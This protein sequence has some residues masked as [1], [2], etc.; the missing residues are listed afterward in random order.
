MSLQSRLFLQHCVS[1]FGLPISVQEKRLLFWKL[2]N[3][4]R[5]LNNTRIA[6]FNPLF[7]ETRETEC[8][9][10][11][12]ALVGIFELPGFQDNDKIDGN[13]LNKSKMGKLLKMRFWLQSLIWILWRILE[14][15]VELW[16]NYSFFS[17]YQYS[18]PTKDLEDFAMTMF[19]SFRKLSVVES[20]KIKKEVLDECT[21]RFRH[22]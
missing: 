1:I 7:V 2:K 8:R 20:M 5:F 4:A 22:A 10:Y 19:A 15:I 6:E 18:N 21:F 9:K 3:C 11:S 14:L 17:D 13:V 16:Q 12:T